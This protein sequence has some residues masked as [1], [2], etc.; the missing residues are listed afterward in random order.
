VEDIGLADCQD[1]TNILIT[2][3]VWLTN[4]ASCRHGRKEIFKHQVIRLV[5]A[6][7]EMISWINKHDP[8]LELAALESVGEF[9]FDLLFK[10]SKYKE[11]K[12][13]LETSGIFN[14]MVDNYLRS[15]KPSLYY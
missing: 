4:L 8:G 2:C 14:L 11:R 9:L 7:F 6:T 15:S 3:Y 1:L 5:A 13:E 10:F 12:T